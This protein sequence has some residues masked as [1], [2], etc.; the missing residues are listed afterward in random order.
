MQKSLHKIL[1][2]I[3]EDHDVETWTQETSTKKKV[4]KLHST[5]NLYDLKHIG[6]ITVVELHK[7]GIKTKEHLLN[8]VQ[9]QRMMN[10][11]KGIHLYTNTK[12][13]FEGMEKL[14]HQQCFRLISLLNLY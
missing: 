2:K 8:I 13:I 1:A 3:E 12:K 9:K 7:R 14:R 5:S 4:V 11:V 10:G 6:P